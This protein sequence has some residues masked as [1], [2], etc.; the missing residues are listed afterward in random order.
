MSKTLA[1]VLT[2]FLVL[3]SLAHEARAQSSQ[4]FI[5]NRP[6]A[7]L[8]LPYFEVDLDKPSGMTTLFSINNASATAVL[9]HVTVWSDL[10]VPVFGFNVYLTGYDMQTIDLREVLTGT[11]PRTASAGQDPQ[12]NISPQG[13]LSQ[14]INFASCFGQ[15]PP[16]EIPASLQAH[17]R[18]ALT[19]GPSSYYEGKCAGRNLGTPGIARGYVTVDTVNSCTLLFPS[20][21]GYFGPGGTGYATNQNVLWGDYQ[22]L[23]RSADFAAGDALV[24][25]QANAVD[26][27]TNVSGQY[28]FYGR[29]VGF[30]AA[31]NRE[32]LSTTFAARFVAAKDYKQENRALLQQILPP[33]TELLVWRDTKSSATAFSCGGAPSW[34]PLA[35]SSLAAFDEQEN[36]ESLNATTPF[37]AAT[38]RVTVASNALPVTPESG[39][40]YLNLNTPVTGQVAGLAKPDAAQAWVTVLHRVYQ[41]P[42]GGR[43]DVG[44]RAV[45]LDSARTP[46]DYKLSLP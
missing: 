34:Y 37:G 21:V 11:V 8:L 41:G 3:T 17:M 30:T 46:R 12:R 45:R 36:P 15:L 1:S 4:P 32:P 19:G 2:A 6:G 5:A 29:F 22:Y 33:A 28:T 31:D 14:D 7:T 13:L 35:Q 43:Y 38:Q 16:P 26:P 24:S 44:S 9:G 39:W 10:G 25:L 27:E 20:D 40:L 23:D 42:T 18:S